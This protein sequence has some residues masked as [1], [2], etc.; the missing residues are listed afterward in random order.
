MEKLGDSLSIERME[1]L[2]RDGKV[3]YN[4][5]DPIYKDTW[6][7]PRGGY[8]IVRCFLDNPGKYYVI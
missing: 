3:A 4:F 6:T 8:T 5:K 2:I 7:V 1:N